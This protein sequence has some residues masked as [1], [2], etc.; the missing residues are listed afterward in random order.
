MAATNPA[1]DPG[2]A[3]TRKQVKFELEPELRPIAERALAV[4]ELA[5]KKAI[6][7][8]A[9]PKEYPMPAGTGHLE[10][11]MYARLKQ[12]PADRRKKSA[13]QVMPTLRPGAPRRFP[14]SARRRRSISAPPSRSSTR[15][16]AQPKKEFDPDRLLG[17]ARQRRGRARIRAEDRD[18]AVHGR[19]AAH[20]QGRLPRARRTSGAATSSSSSG[21][22]IDATGD[23]RQLSRFRVS[24][25]FDS[26]EKVT[27]SPP[28]IFATFPFSSDNSITVNGKTKTVGWPRTYYVTF[29]PAEID[30]GGF[31]DFATELYKKAKDL[32]TKYV[33]QAVGA[34]F[35]GAARRGD[36]RC[37]RQDRRLG[38]GQAV[39]PAGQVVGGRHLHP[40]HLDRE[41]AR[42][43]RRLQGQGRR[44]R[45]TSPRMLWWKQHG[46]HYEVHY[47]WHLY[48]KK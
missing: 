12:R 40:A 41:G 44:H 38:D 28:K 7:H 10:Q 43:E 20:P 19:R 15:S 33:A 17:P 42:R 18:R 26:G 23:T 34:Y 6:A 11:L 39:R 1:A 21:V 14:V 22:S 47:D 5:A 25:D 30:H 35:G 36:R 4:L 37:R 8:D 2:V 16:A 46:G 48:A 24:S 32:V 29:L 3:E 45:L 13:A 27:Y 9:A 31:P